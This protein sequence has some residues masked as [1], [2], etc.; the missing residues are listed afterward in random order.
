MAAAGA[1][2]PLAAGCCVFGLAPSSY[3]TG[4]AAKNA[5]RHLDVPTQLQAG[6]A[7]RP[8]PWGFDAP[9]LGS[10]QTKGSL[11]KFRAG[12]AERRLPFR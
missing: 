8:R 2:T 12:D 10:L 1:T 11:A 4:D 6:D 5:S 3:P 7:E 9:L